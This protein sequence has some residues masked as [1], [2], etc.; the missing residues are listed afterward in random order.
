MNNVP[1]KTPIRMCVCCRGRFAQ[2][3]LYRLQYLPQ[4]RRLI[5][6]NGLGRSFYLCKSCADNER[7][8]V[9]LCRVCRIDKK[10]KQILSDN[11]KEIICQH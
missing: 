7:A 11:L 8:I 5:T 3:M 6:Y 10:Q 4:S 9:A 1:I 2:A